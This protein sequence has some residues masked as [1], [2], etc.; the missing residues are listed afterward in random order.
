M[1]LVHPHHT[2]ANI[3]T[4]L[5]LNIDVCVCVCVC[6]CKCSQGYTQMTRSCGSEYQG[7]KVVQTIENRILQKQDTTLLQLANKTFRECYRTHFWFVR[8]RGD[9]AHCL[10]IATVLLRRRMCGKK[11]KKSYRIR[12]WRFWLWRCRRRQSCWQSPME[13]ARYWLNQTPINVFVLNVSIEY[14]C[15]GIL[16]CTTRTLWQT[17]AA[18]SWKILQLTGPG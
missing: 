9:T 7:N 10:L 8:R 4:H 1:L 14:S 16:F 5:I 18:L 12:L 11:R 17:I 6:V 2:F 15:V 13:R 3:S